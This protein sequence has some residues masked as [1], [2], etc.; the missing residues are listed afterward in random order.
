M[1]LRGMRA[2]AGKVG[3]AG[4]E[5][6]AAE[7]PVGPPASGAAGLLQNETCFPPSEKKYVD[8]MVA[9]IT[10]DGPTL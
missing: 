5:D 7:F 4:E 8:E 3:F 9:E 2:A 10:V 6:D 1:W